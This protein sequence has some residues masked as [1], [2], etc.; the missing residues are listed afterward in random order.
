M[1]A[2][3]VA[4]AA[5]ARTLTEALRRLDADALSDLLTL[6]PDL[7]YPVPADV[8]EL[9]AQAT[10]TSSVGR[11]LDGLNAWQRVVAEAL[12]ALPDPVRLPSIVE[13]LHAEL[14]AAARAVADLRDR[15]LLW[16]DDE[17][18]HLVRAARDH[19]GPYPGGLAPPSSRPL[20]PTE[21][22]TRLAEVGSDARASSIGCCGTP[23]ERSTVPTGP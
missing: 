16:G 3:A 15:A 21:I 13:L 20:S 18:L 5:P 10:T 22:D 2:P 17:E 19:L 9:S 4:T 6:R 11:A 12:A 7:A 8:A 14:P 1:A 23:P